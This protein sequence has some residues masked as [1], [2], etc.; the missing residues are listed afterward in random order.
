MGVYYSRI[1]EKE[2]EDWQKRTFQK[3]LN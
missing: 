2:E 1:P 3:L